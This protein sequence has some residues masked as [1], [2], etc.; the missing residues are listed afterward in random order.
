MILHSWK[1]LK[2][3]IQS[4]SFV[5]VSGFYLQRIPVFNVT[6][7]AFRITAKEMDKK[8]KFSTVLFSP[9]GCLCKMQ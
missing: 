6:I 2:D 7:A 4:R 1:W 5:L 9:F 3:R 8:I